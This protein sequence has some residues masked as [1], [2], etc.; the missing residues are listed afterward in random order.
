METTNWKDI[1]D[2]VT[3][4]QGKESAKPNPSFFKILARHALGQIAL[5]AKPVVGT[6]TNTG[7]PAP[8]TLTGNT[9]PLPIDCLKVE[10]VEWDGA[11][12]S[13]KS[14]DDLNLMFPS[15]RTETGETPAYYCQ[16]GTNIVLD[17]APS[18]TTTGMLVIRG[19]Q[20]LPVFSDTPTDP[21]PLAH[22]PDGHQFAPAYYILA[23]LPVRAD[24]PISAARKQ[25]YTA[26]WQSELQSIIDDVRTR[27]LEE[28][29]Y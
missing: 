9:C 26:L 7:D 29:T 21:N 23:N 25:E 16:E 2:F 12:L 14:T 18:G 11:Q 6:W 13:R 19:V 20:T 8:I 10:H 28:W 15:W 24:D 3:E 27:K 5:K 17:L 1:I 22:I 4:V